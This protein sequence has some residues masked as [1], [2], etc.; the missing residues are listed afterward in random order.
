M[1]LLFFIS[2]NPLM[3]RAN[4]REVYAALDKVEFMAVADF[5]LTP[6][7]EMADIVLPAATWLEM[8]YIGDYWKRHGW[9]LP[10]RKAAQVGECRSDHDMLNDLAKRVGLAEH[11]WDDFEGALDWILEP[12][13][14]TFQDF[15][16]ADHLRGE[17]RYRKY[18]EK[19][20]STLTRKFELSSTKLAGWGYDPLPQFREPPESPVSRPDLVDDYPYIL[21]TGARLPGFFHSENRQLPLVREL[22]PDPEVEIHPATAAKE[23][24]ADGDW[25]TIASPHGAVRQRA[26][27]SAGLHPQVVSAQHGWWFPERPEPGHG[28]DESN[29]N[30]I[31]DNGYDKCDPAMG[32]TSIRTLLCRISQEQQGPPA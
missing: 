24:I 19:G 29:I 30:V 22:H 13:G 7:A 12:S 1:K 11:W 10:R 15:L 32:A 3:T 9:L 26:K 20:F 8:D 21:I 17:V 23:G 31:I 18:R 2:S 27:F 25:V 28:W 4:A 6:T 14:L 5:F 16:A